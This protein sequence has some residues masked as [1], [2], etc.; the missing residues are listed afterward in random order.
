MSRKW[1]N[2]SNRGYKKGQELLDRF[3]FQ[4]QVVVKIKKL[5]DPV[6]LDSPNM[7]LTKIPDIVI[8]PIAL[9][10]IS[11]NRWNSLFKLF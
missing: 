6:A 1:E 11:F 9:L 7:R 5:F 10:S 2:A 4:I 3:I 8:I